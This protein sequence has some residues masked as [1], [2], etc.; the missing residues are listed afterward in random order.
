[1]LRTSA[2]MK[3]TKRSL[4]N[5]TSFWSIELLSDPITET[6]Q[7]ESQRVFYHEP[8]PNDIV[9]S[10]I[11]LYENAELSYHIDC[12][13]F[14]L[15]SEPILNPDLSQITD[16]SVPISESQVSIAVATFSMSSSQCA[17][18]THVIHGIRS[19][20]N[21]ECRCS[22]CFN[23]SEPTL[24][25]IEG[26]RDNVRVTNS[27][28]VEWIHVITE[29]ATRKQLPIDF[30][31][32]SK[33]VSEEYEIFTG[34]NREQFDQLR[35]D[36]PQRIL[37]FLLGIEHQSSVSDVLSSVTASLA[38]RFLPRFLGY[39]SCHIT[40]EEIAL[41]HTSPFVRSLI[42]L[43]PKNICLVFDATYLYLEKSSS[44]QLQRQT[45]SNYKL[46]N[47]CKPI[48]VTT[49][50]GYILAADGPYYGDNNYNDGR[51]LKSMLTP[52]PDL[53]AEEYS[54]LTFLRPRDKATL[55]RGFQESTARLEELH[56]DYMM[57]LFLVGSSSICHIS[58]DR[59]Q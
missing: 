13:D 38:K 36:L 26:T 15:N 34:L 44:F 40:W 30:N 2:P 56:I 8:M 29:E 42:T 6:S 27:E 43:P 45:Y 9:D 4:C 50:T 49:D 24:Q 12:E 20:S 31:A 28:L 55:D 35:L 25:I 18:S 39:S 51:I 10:F 1:M 32:D 57:Q 16:Q 17:Q 41:R 58:R 47:L 54:L 59:K 52:S 3:T 5:M 37:A 48:V 22:L 53:P 33:M 23:P 11:D 19:Y 7:M 14:S 46:Q 21:S